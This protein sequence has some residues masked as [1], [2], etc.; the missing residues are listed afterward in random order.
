M[1]GLKELVM[2]NNSI[3][4]EGSSE[5]LNGLRNN[6]ELI[7]LHVGDTKSEHIIKEIFHWI[8]LN[9]A[10]RRIFRDSNL[11]LSMWP[12]MLSRLTT[13]MDV[14]YHFLSQKPEI[15]EPVQI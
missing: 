7:Y 10:G 9:Q 13:D 8:R 5:L 12:Q 6:M 11:P 3:D 1:R 14:L 2:I 15:L 4:H